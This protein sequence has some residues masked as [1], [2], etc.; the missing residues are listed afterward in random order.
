MITLFD[1]M[2]HVAGTSYK[3]DGDWQVLPLTDDN[4]LLRA[5][6]SDQLVAATEVDMPYHVTQDAEGCDGYAVVKDADGEIMGCHDTEAEAND[7]MAA[8][9]ANEADASMALDD[10]KPAFQE[11]EQWRAVV[12]PEGV[13]SG[14]SPKRTFAPN[15]LTTR[16]LPLP[17]RWVETDV[18]FHDG[19]TIVGSMIR[20]VRANGKVWAFGT[21][22]TD[23][24][25]V[26]A[27]RLVQTGMQRWVSV[28]ADNIDE[29]SVEYVFPEDAEMDDEL[30]MMLAMPEEVIF[31]QAR[32]AGLTIVQIP[33]F[34]EAVIEDIDMEAPAATG[35]PEEPV[36]IYNLDEVPPTGAMIALVPDPDSISRLVVEG[37]IVP[38]DL[39]MTLV[40]LG[41]AEA[42][43][44]SARAA[45]L[46][47]VEGHQRTGPVEARAFGASIFNPDGEE[48]ASV[49]VL[50]ASDAHRIRADLAAQIEHLIPEDAHDFIAHTTLGYLADPGQATAALEEAISRVGD[51]RYD[52]LRVAFASEVTDFPL[53]TEDLSLVASA[54]PMEPPDGWFQNPGLLG[55]TPFTVDDDGR[56]FGHLAVWGTCHTSVQN[57]CT[58][59][60][61]EEEFSYF[62]LGEVVCASGQHIPVG[63]ITMGTGHAGGHLRQLAAAEHYDNTGTA[64]AD[65]VAGSDQHGIWLAGAARPGLN[66]PQLRAL[67]AAKL[68]GDWR[69]FGTRLRLVAA[70]CVNVPGFPIPRPRAGV[71]HGEQVSLAASGVVIEP[72]QVQRVPGI[73]LLA[74]RVA[75]S[76][77]R[78]TK[79]RIKELA[80]RLGR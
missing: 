35:A 49:L 12:A 27:R 18:G 50:E 57:A 75:A 51:V 22:D 79:S 20:Q 54:F 52:R 3:G 5:L 24:D 21:W 62:Q 76:I 59:P 14:D 41:D 33:A 61:H 38:D 28:D 8:L 60:P 23:A 70:L 25:A 7:Q 47:A 72:V 55:P 13:P 68:S 37:G 26:E 16:D 2:R 69:K 40:Y 44:E 15:S 67:R 43:D 1:K 71:D 34:Q 31:H 36:S 30:G 65:V 80:A 19:A 45:V 17:L 11:G 64:V 6:D 4:V 32:V 39:H 9:Y 42:L 66:E 77:G 63:Q 56:V 10:G 74:E 53:D 73:D 48:P 78:D 58:T 46:A 29:S